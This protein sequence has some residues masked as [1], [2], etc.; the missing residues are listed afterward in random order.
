MRFVVS[1]DISSDRHRQ[2]AADILIALLPRVQYSVFEGE[3][4][5]ALLTRAV[6]RIRP[7]LDPR[8]DSLRVYRLCGACSPRIEVH[9]RPGAEAPSPVRVL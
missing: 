1:Y 3:V 7:L 5:D 9:G 2:K 4:P 6:Q 8:T